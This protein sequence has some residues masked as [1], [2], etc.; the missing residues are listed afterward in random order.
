MG[1]H[2]NTANALET[3]RT[4][5][6]VAMTDLT[7][8][9]AGGH[10]KLLQRNRMYDLLRKEK[11]F[12]ILGDFFLSRRQKYE[13]AVRAANRLVQLRDELRLS[14]DDWALMKSCVELFGTAPQLYIHDELFTR[15]L[16]TMCD[17]E[18]AKKWVPLAKNYRIIGCYAQ[19]ELGHG[20]NV[21]GLETTATFD[22]STDEFVLHSPTITASKWW[23][24]ALGKTATH[25]VVYARLIIGPKDYGVHPFFFQIRSTETME[26]LPGITVGDIGP[27]FGFNKQDNGYLRFNQYR[28][29]RTNMLMKVAKVDRDGHYTRAKVDKL[30]YL[31]MTAIR[32]DMVATSFSVLAR[33]VTVAIRYSS[34]RRQFSA[35]DGEEEQAVLNYGT[36]QYRLFPLLATSYVLFFTG[37]KFQSLFN[38]L[39]EDLKR[40]P[41][42][43]TVVPI[44]N[45]MHVNLSGLKSLCTSIASDGIEECRK[46]CGGHGYSLSSGLGELFV[47]YVHTTTAEGDNY[48]LTQQTSRFLL[49]EF[50]K[51]LQGKADPAIAGSMIG[52]LGRASELLNSRA[53][54]MTKSKALDP[55]WQLHA[56]H[57][58]VAFLLKRTGAI[59][60]QQS[61]P[62]VGWNR[63]QMDAHNI[64][65]A[66]SLSILVASAIES[67]RNAEKSHPK[68]AGHFKLLTDIFVVYHLVQGA[69]DWLESGFL[70]GSHVEVLRATL[71]D[72]FAE[73]RPDA[74]ALVDGFSIPDFRLLSAL[75]SSDGRPYDALLR[76]V[77]MEPMNQSPVLPEHSHVIS[78]LNRPQPKL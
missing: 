73:L 70:D 52:Y 75:G 57:H 5:S 18:Q 44:L 51:S 54:D 1:R 69:G 15:T 3:E 74:V 11:D 39:N 29:P 12:Q 35:K 33:A 24:G 60:M 22:A 78:M 26:P 77:A 38:K 49:K 53:G 43:P 8:Y 56:F 71:L 42:D 65:K 40:D 28:I 67:C 66:H 2:T 63:V 59:L 27:K 16:E 25:G 32:S 64:A 9:I 21:R 34:I 68:L 30:A 41:N 14:D 55:E 23:V 10:A 61:D 31:T 7:G 45:E 62:I 20:S 36:Q 6:R 76:W 19:T 37:Q 13:S 46:C 72:L 47:D 4:Q 50:G 48:M 17:E 58:R